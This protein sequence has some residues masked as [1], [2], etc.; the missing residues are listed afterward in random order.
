MDEAKK[1]LE[2]VRETEEKHPEF[3]TRV[4]KNKE[5]EE[6]RERVSGLETGQDALQ[7]HVNERLNWHKHRLNALGRLYREEKKKRGWIDLLLA[8]AVLTLALA[9]IAS[10]FT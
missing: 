5:F 3:V 6:L 2:G 10:W 4:V 7:E 1:D 9:E 8:V